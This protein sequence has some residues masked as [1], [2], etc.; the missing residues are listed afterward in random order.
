MEVIGKRS[1]EGGQNRNLI[2]AVVVVSSFITPFLG[3]SVNIALPVMGQY[4]SMTAVQLSWVAMSFLLSSAVFLVPLGRLADLVGRVKIFVYGTLIVSVSSFLCAWSVTTELLIASRV[5]QSIGSA[6]MFGTNMAIITSVFPPNQRGKAIGINVTAVYLGLSLA[7][8]LGGFLTQSLGW[9]SIFWIS[10]GLGLLVGLTALML[11]R[12]R[13][14]ERGP[15]PFDMRGAL[16]YVVAM[17]LFMFGLSRLPDFSA[18]ILTLIGGILLLAFG[19]IELRTASPVFNMHL[20][21]KNR[22][23]GLSNLAALINYATTFAVTFILSLYLQYIIGLSPRDAGM[24]LVVQPGL[25]AIVASFSGKLS[26]RIQPGRIASAG[27]V[28]ITAGLVLLLFLKE[29]TS[30]VYLIT[31]LFLMGTGFGLFSSPNTNAIMSSVDKPQLG[32]ASATVATM[33]LTGQMV[34]MALATLVIHIYIGQAQITPQNHDLFLKTIP[35]IFGI[36]I[37]LNLVGIWASLARNSPPSISFSGSAE[38]P[39]K[40]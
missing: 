38:S 26:D 40:H 3:S 11:L 10:G 16:L 27:M 5:L 25:M 20:L 32:T 39:P 1:E 4:F 34:S 13:T 24:L 35:V 33:R 15:E 9:K 19:W 14:A 21:L 37:S 23:F 18:I 8:L 29:D 31:S 2:L 28:V 30:T 22:V 36:F 17:S 7:P 6:M 12:I